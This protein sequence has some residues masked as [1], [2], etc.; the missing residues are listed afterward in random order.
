MRRTL[1]FILVVILRTADAAAQ[2]SGWLDRPTENWNRPGDVL[3]K[4]P[5][6][7]DWARAAKTCKSCFRAARSPEERA[8]ASMG[9]H[10][11]NSSS[12]SRGL[13]VVLGASALDGMCR[14]EQYHEFVFSRRKYAGT[15]SPVRMDARTDGESR[16]VSFP[17][18]ARI[19]VEFSRYAEDDALCCPSRIS[20]A[21]FEVGDVAGKPVVVL[22]GVPIT[23]NN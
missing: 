22:V 20:I 21:T 18:G 2:S 6:G 9:W 11:I 14:P 7:F 8:V 1:A 17:G 10:I 12:D 4:A 13:V 19:V 16:G 15:L 5:Q 23:R 3:P